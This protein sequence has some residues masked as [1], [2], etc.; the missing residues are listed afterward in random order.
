MEFGQIAQRID[1][2]KA[3]AD[4]M[5]KQAQTAAAGVARSE[6]REIETRVLAMLQEA[7]A[8]ASARNSAPD[9]TQL[10]GEIGSLRSAVEQLSARVAEGPDMRTVAEMER[11][12]AELGLRIDQVSHPAGGDADHLRDLEDRIAE[13][14]QRLDDVP[15]QRA[16]PHALDLLERNIA[17]VDERVGRT[18]QQLRHIETM[19]NAIRDLY[20]SLEQTRSEAVRRADEAATL[21]VLTPGPAMGPSPELLA[22]EEGLRAVRESAANA[23]RRNQETL[24]AVHET[25]SQIVDKIAEIE[26]APSRVPAASYAAVEQPVVPP[27]SPEPVP[28]T[29]QAHQAYEGPGHSAAPGTA[30]PALPSGD[31]FIAAARRAAQA[32]ATR[33]SSLRAEFGP[34]AKQ[35]EQKRSSVLDRFRRTP[36]DDV[37]LAGTTKSHVAP[38]DASASRRR[39]LLLAGIV[40]LA[41]VSAFAFNILVRKPA[42]PPAVPGATIEQPAQSAPGPQGSLNL[43]SGP[44]ITG[45]LPPPVLAAPARLPP[46]DIGNAALREAAA[47]GNPKAQ[48]VV[49]TRYLEGDSTTPQDAA[50]AAFW[51]EQ[52]AANG[53]APAQYRIA[54]MFERGKGVAQDAPSAL[55]W[56]EKAA[57]LGNVKSMHN[58]AVLIMGGKAGTVDRA[59]ALS[60]FEAAARHGLRD[61]Q[62]NLALLYERGLGTAPDKSK[63]Y[64]WYRVAAQQG[65]TQAVDR[66]AAARQVSHPVATRQARHAGHRLGAGDTGGGGQCRGQ[67]RSRLGGRRLHRPRLG[68]RNSL[69][70]RRRPRM[71]SSPRRR[72]C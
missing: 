35:D 39:R 54:T 55:Y 23:D 7:Q 18:E 16:G 72:S 43:P 70:S 6:L 3:A 5:A 65:D 66:A 71:I 21:G 22:L 41:A 37:P 25:L 59:K 10:R 53:L 69:E 14:G 26:A 36:K 33:P 32:A 50:K 51:Y 58:S 15:A 62:F 30:G 38:A 13:L 52:A 1:S 67:R 60:L 4:Q 11:R 48:F 34:A 20:G 61:S 42:P 28:E 40:L 64:Y 31:D 8:A 57:A 12:L 2:V 29:Y 47:S 9:G 49:A 63:A 68:L 27:P 44:A 56:Y 19:E 46:P 24:A 17:A 45:S